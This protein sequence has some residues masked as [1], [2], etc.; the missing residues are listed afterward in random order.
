VWRL[1][2]AA[3][4]GQTGPMRSWALLGFVSLAGCHGGVKSR[5]VPPP[6]PSS[7]TPEVVEAM[8]GPAGVGLGSPTPSS[9]AP[10]P[11]D[12]STAASAGTPDDARPP[13][14]VLGFPKNACDTASGGGGAQVSKGCGS[15]HS[16]LRGFAP[17]LG[18]C[19]EAAPTREGAQ[20]LEIH[21]D[22]MGQT[23]SVETPGDLFGETAST[24]VRE[25]LMN[26]VV[27]PSLDYAFFR[28]TIE[29]PR[30]E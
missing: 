23:V 30:P 6:V 15:P 21:I 18:H 26:M 20:V 11:A 17:R 22:D 13:C 9:S 16:A 3:L 25:V 7:P 12:A 8:E 14:V 19:L 28:A 24:C 2:R 27:Y 29:C 1:A 5:S 4:L 10:D